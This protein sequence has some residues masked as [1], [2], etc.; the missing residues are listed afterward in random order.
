MRTLIQ[1]FILLLF[2][3]FSVQ[4]Q[5]VV[6][7]DGVQVKIV[8]PSQDL[9]L[10]DQQTQ[11]LVGTIKTLV[12]TEIGKTLG[13]DLGDEQIKRFAR[14]QYPDLYSSGS[15]NQEKEIIQRYV[16]ALKAVVQK[17]ENP[18]VTYERLLKTTLSEEAWKRM[19]VQFGS[20][21]GIEK[22]ER[23]LR[24]SEKD[25]IAERIMTTSGSI[26]EEM[27]R[28][29]ICGLKEVDDELRGNLE[30]EMLRE[31][32]LRKDAFNKSVTQYKCLKASSEWVNEFVRTRMSFEGDTA[33]SV[34]DKVKF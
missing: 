27:V 9:I 34:M 24:R 23:Q 19:V 6:F 14:D 10:P 30:R 25:V 7:V 32:S 28:K 20:L 15:V 29:A 18:N 5:I 21:D 17:K 22:W 4:A 11:Y 16:D 2:S 3:S 33:K 13:I 8:G 26:R 31:D 12:W 1:S